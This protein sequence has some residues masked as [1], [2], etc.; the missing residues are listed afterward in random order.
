MFSSDNVEE[1]GLPGAGAGTYYAAASV[2][3]DAA[4]MSKSHIETRFPDTSS[5]NILL[6]RDRNRTG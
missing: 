2:V 1:R 6:A 5:L 3:S 4:E